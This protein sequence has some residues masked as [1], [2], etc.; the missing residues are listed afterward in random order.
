MGQ[1]LMA[2]PVQFEAANA[3][4]TAPRGQED[5]VGSLPVYRDGRSCTSCWELSELELEEIVLTRRVYLSMQGDT[6]PPVFVGSALTVGELLVHAA[7][8]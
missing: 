6:H 5:S 4:L 3:V 1:Q 8:S 2:H 7:I